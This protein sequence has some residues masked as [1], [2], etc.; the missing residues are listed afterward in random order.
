MASRIV[1]EGAKQ[2]S[3]EQSSKVKKVLILAGFPSLDVK[4]LESQM[5][6]PS[7]PF[8][9]LA[10]AMN[11][12]T[13]R[14][15]MPCL[16]AA[17]VGTYL[18]RAGIQMEFA[19]PYLE[20]VNLEGAD[21]IGI[22]STFMGVE[23]V[24]RLCNRVKER[25]P[26]AIIVLGGPLSWSVVPDEILRT[27]PAI[28]IIVIGEGEQTFLE[29]V[30]NLGNPAALCSVKGL[31]L[32]QNGAAL[33]T[34]AR[35]PLQP[36]EWLFPNWRLL[37]IPSPKFLPVLPVET[38]RG[39]PYRCAYCSETTFW[40]KPVR[41]RP[42]E[43]VVDEISHCI[44]EYGID[45]FRFVDSCLS[46]PP[47]RCAQLCSL[48]K[49]RIV[50]QNVPLKWSSYARVNNLTPALLENMRSAG[51]VALDIGAESGDEAILHTMGKRYSST[52]IVH[53]VRRAREVGIITNLNIVV[54]FPGETD[55]SVERT[56]S[57]LQDAAPD[58]FSCFSLFVAPNT[59]L[60]EQPIRYGLE[61]SGL[62]WKHSTMTSEQ[63]VQAMLKVCN[64][65]SSST[66]FTGGEYFA[67]F[68][69]SLG[70]SSDEVRELYRAVASM[71]MKQGAGSAQTVVSKAAAKLAPYV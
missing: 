24:A 63:A 40:G 33:A 11:K 60:C 47:D 17:A 46:A 52:E 37:G 18:D 61:G 12:S 69:L 48:L 68:L 36:E 1:R 13:L 4:D 62:V 53:I 44:Q 71:S 15:S 67:T 34:G 31:V 9:I 14:L 66:L 43:A 32:R 59:P 26:T 28:D 8:A 57:M 20:E 65:V 42:I 7:R 16:G 56:I 64:G 70:Y 50:R 25:N 21:V 5:G 22:S 54:G 35:L 19:Y 55:A 30:R 38:A 6:L 45:A 41:Y 39:C 51:C 49:E 58:T 27:V 2:M 3:R 23:D 10:A 29:V